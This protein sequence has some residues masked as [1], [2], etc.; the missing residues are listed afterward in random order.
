VSI[1]PLTGEVPEAPQTPLDREKMR[2]EVA[3]S[4]LHT[5]VGTIIKLERSLAA[6]KAQ[7]A[8]STTDSA[9]GRMATAIS[10][11]YVERLKKGKGWKFG[12]KR[13]KA[14]IARLKEGYEPEFICRAI[15]GIAIGA[16]QNRDTGVRYDDLELVC[17][18]EVYLD[19]FHELA[20]RNNAPTLLTPERSRELRGEDRLTDSDDDPSV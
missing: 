10:R 3:E 13:R 14:V 9:E 1:D 12:E 15:D 19:R 17:R 8:R 20:E 6:L 7:I 18:D 2:A 5:A 4:D 11:Y 16:N